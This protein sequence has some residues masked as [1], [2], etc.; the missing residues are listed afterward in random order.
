MAC[1]SVRITEFVLLRQAEEAKAGWA[2]SERELDEA[3]AKGLLASKGLKQ[4]QDEAAAAAA[5]AAAADT[6]TATEKRPRPSNYGG[7]VDGGEMGKSSSSVSDNAL[8]RKLDELMG[9]LAVRAMLCRLLALLLSLNRSLHCS[10]I[11]LATSDLL[12]LVI[13]QLPLLTARNA[14]V[15]GTSCCW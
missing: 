9:K 6:A 5:V 2:E 15:R 11:Q 4:C 14:G 8:E 10:D 3:L 1:A 13:L 12:G 7:T